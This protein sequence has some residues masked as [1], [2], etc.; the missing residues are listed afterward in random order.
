MDPR[1]RFLL[2]R[3]AGAAVTA[4]AL[5]PVARYTRLGGLEFAVGLPTSE[6]P[7]QAAAFQGALALA[8]TRR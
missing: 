8:G 2:G 4:T 3:A 5:R 6:L 1:T 7:L